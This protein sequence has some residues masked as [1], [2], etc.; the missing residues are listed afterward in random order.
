M[1]FVWIVVGIAVGVAI[2]SPGY[3]GAHRMGWAQRW[4]AIHAALPW[5]RVRRRIAAVRRAWRRPSAHGVRAASAPARAE[6]LS[7]A[8]WQQRREIY[9]PALTAAGA[10]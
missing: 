10:W 8:W 6:D 5:Q 9:K 3:C 2:P 1:M 7:W 4:D